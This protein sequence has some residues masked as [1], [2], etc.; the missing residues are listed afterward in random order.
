MV[1]Q[2]QL[3][4]EQQEPGFPEPRIE[5]ALAP[6]AQI[7]PSGAEGEPIVASPAAELARQEIA[8]IESDLGEIEASK[9]VDPI[10]RLLELAKEKNPNQ[11]VLVLNKL[12]QENLPVAA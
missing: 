5:V 6:E 8:K 10:V 3:T 2:S 12:K 7:A 9:P 1:D 11:I 4:I